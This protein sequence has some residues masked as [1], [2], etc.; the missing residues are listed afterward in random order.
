MPAANTAS[1][2]GSVARTFHWLTA[3]LILAAWPIGLIANNLSHQIL[4]PQVQ[5]T[6]AQILRTVFLFSMHK[7]LGVSVFFVALA[8]IAWALT[9]PRPGLLNADRKLESGLAETVHWLLYGSLVLVPLS[10]WIHH[11][12]TT[13]YAPIW[14][15]FG[16]SLPFV[17]KDAAWAEIAG[18]VHE[19][20][21]K[22]L[23]VSVLLHVA[24]AVKHHVIDRDATLRR[25]VTGRGADTPV[26][27]HGHSLVPPVLALVLAGLALVGGGYA[28]VYGHASGA[29]GG[30]A[31]AEVASDWTVDEGSLQITVQQMGSEV[32]GS[33]A[34]W[35]AAISFEPRD[36]P[37]SAG[38]VEVTVAIPSLTLGTV[39]SQAMGGEYFDAEAFPTASFVAE[40]LRTEDGYV[41]P[42]TL[43]IRDTPVAAELPFTLE[44]DGDTAR[45]AGQMQVD[46]M[47][48]GI[49]SGVKDEKTLAFGVTI[50]VAL[51]ATRGA[52]G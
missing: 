24:G 43:T 23:L 32:T 2:Y 47:D 39:T 42:G 49:G 25:M 38:T 14:W 28:G 18:G 20:L 8:R 3:L 33:F 45:M 44:L 17:P 7:T 40:I 12:A 36:T 13:G 15:P 5:V 11:A 21:T 29:T 35:T 4:D 52:G 22:V 26:P 37:G 19:V 41:A 10:G 50:D 9:Q 51:T 30:G 48:F 34:D 27:A 46:R 31:L 1:S 6:E 16:Q